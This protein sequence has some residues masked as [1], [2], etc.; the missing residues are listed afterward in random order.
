MGLNALR[1]SSDAGAH[2]LTSG[3]RRQL[4]MLA[5]DVDDEVADAAEEVLERI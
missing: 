4:R 2:E 3:V 5:Q 1:S